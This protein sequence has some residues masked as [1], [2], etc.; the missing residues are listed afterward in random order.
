MK[1]LLR[2]LIVSAIFLSVPIFTMAQYPPHPNGGSGP[3]GDNTPVGGG[4]PIGEGVF[5]LISMGF[6]YGTKK[7]I[8]FKKIS[9]KLLE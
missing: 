9:R 3:T 7:V 8:Q 4:A 5:L 6:I 1:K 2:I